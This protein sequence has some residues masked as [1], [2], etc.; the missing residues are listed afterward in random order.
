MRALRRSLG[1]TGRKRPG[2]P[3]R[4]AYVP[5]MEAW[6]ARGAYAGR[7]DVNAPP[8]PV[9]SPRAIFLFRNDERGPTTTGGMEAAELSSSTP[10]PVVVPGKWRKRLAWVLKLVSWFK[11]R[12]EFPGYDSGGGPRGV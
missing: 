11:R 3:G 9:V 4:G 7:P 2:N 1:L 5:Y 6:L 8:R 12:P 10:Q